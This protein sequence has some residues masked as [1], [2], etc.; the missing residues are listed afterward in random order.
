MIPKRLVLARLCALPLLLSLF[1]AQAA[2][3]QQ[4]C[5]Q[6]AVSAASRAQSVFSP[7]QEMELGDVIAEHVQQDY[8][9]LEDA[10]V[11]GFLRRIG[12]RLVAQLPPSEMRYQFFVV[13]L[14]DA[15]AFT[16]PGG[17]IYVTRKLI[18]FA[19]SEDEVA[20][21][22]AHELGHA[23]SGQTAADMTRRFREVL[24]L[25]ADQTVY[26]LDLTAKV[27]QQ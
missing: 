13:D 22:L 16:M 26:L 25:T 11:T 10:E 19:A 18:A 20:G 5:Q 24:V 4:P 14:P 12:E 1:S 2:A 9:V 3:R 7:R 21:V 23:A 27:S 15:N 6:P 17:R 8:R